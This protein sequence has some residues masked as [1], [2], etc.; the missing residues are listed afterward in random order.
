M[1][2]KTDEKNNRKV[3]RI[4]AGRLVLSFIAFR[5]ENM[6]GIGLTEDNYDR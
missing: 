3:D 5:N 1:K 4:T 6:V 2:T